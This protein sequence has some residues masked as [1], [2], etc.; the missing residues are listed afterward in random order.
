[1]VMNCKSRP[2][3]F[4]SGKVMKILIM[5]GEELSLKILGDFLRDLGH[6]VVCLG[7]R[8]GLLDEKLCDDREPVDVVIVDPETLSNDSLELI[9]EIHG[10]LEGADIVIMS[11]VKGALSYLNAISHGIYGYL[12]KPV[13]LSELELLLTRMNERRSALSQSAS[14]DPGMKPEPEGGSD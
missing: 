8:S 12:T 1:M 13:H 10:R 11:H 14:V 4:E 6:E 2:M 5:D 3:I 7:T 9:Q